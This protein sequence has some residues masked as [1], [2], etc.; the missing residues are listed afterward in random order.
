VG[1]TSPAIIVVS[2]SGSTTLTVTAITAWLQ[3]QREQRALLAGASQSVAVTFAPTAAQTYS[4]C[5]Y[6]KVNLPPTR[7]FG[8]VI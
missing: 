5:A 4:G 2:D 1:S 6:Q 8:P 7:T 3:P